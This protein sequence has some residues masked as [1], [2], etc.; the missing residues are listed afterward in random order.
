MDSHSPTRRRAQRETE[1]ETSTNE[2][3]EKKKQEMYKKIDRRDEEILMKELA[4]EQIL[5]MED[6]MSSKPIPLTGL[7]CPLTGEQYYID[8]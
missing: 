8:P 2:E 7:T 1:E 4:I 6:G 3:Q 5:D